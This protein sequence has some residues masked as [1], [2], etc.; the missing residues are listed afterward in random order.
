MNDQ[1]KQHGDTLD[2]YLDGLLTGSAQGAFEGRL[3]QES[4][5]KDEAA[6]QGRIDQSLRRAYQAPSADKMLEK[7]MAAHE[8]KRTEPI[9]GWFGPRLRVYAAAAVIVLGLGVGYRVAMWSLTRPA[10]PDKLFGPMPL[11]SMDSVYERTVRAGFKPTWVCESDKQFAV[12]FFRRVKQ[13]LVLAN[14]SPGTTALGIAASRTISRDTLQLLAT[15]DGSKV[16]VFVDQAEHDRGHAVDAGT[17]LHLFRKRLGPVV[18][19]ELTPLIEPRLLDS[20][21]LVDV[22]QQW[23]ED[24]PDW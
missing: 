3:E 4:Q 11:M 12:S 18:L 6:L 23:L 8:A 14:L 19:Y 22:P 16:M 17:G 2:Q 21:E 9:R 7:A 1:S 10:D 20:I 5:L 13:G 15:V 24:V